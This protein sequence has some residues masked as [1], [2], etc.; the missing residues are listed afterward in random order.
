MVI[1]PPDRLD[2]DV[3]DGLRVAENK[4]PPEAVL[5][6]VRIDRYALPI[7]LIFSLGSTSFGDAVNSEAVAGEIVATLVGSIG[8]IAAVPL[9]TAVAALLAARMS[10]GSIPADEHAHAH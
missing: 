3:G 1:D 5:G 10:P 6:G 4:L 7:L 9:T 2:L 8:L